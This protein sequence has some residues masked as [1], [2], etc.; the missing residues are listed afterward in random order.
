MSDPI[1]T[2]IKRVLRD[3]FK[4]PDDEVAAIEKEIRGFTRMVEPKQSVDVVK[5]DPTDDRTIEC[6]VSG[7]SDYILSGDQ[8][9]LSLGQFASVKIM[10][11]ADFLNIVGRPGQSR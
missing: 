9:R 10:K 5:A 11:V 4:W 2:E 6:A 3:K 8:H 1:M 7:G